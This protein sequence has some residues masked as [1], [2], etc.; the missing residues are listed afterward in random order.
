MVYDAMLCDRYIVMYVCKVMYVCLIYGFDNDV[1]SMYDRV[2]GVSYDV[3]TIVDDVCM[4]YWRALA[5]AGVKSG[6]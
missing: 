6:Y 3:S 2:N 1:M 5:C 4:R